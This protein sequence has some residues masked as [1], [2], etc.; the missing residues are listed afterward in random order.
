MASPGSPFDEIV[1]ETGLIRIA[2]FRCHPED[3]SFHDTGP[4]SNYCFVFP[5]TSVEIQHEHEPAFVANPNVVTFYNSGQR[6]QR[7]PISPEGDCCDWFGIAPDLV[8]DVIA[9]VDARAGDRMEQPFG[10]SHGKADAPTYLFQ[11]S[12]FT[13]VTTARRVDELFVEEAVITLLNQVIGSI[14]PVRRPARPAA[15]TP[16]HRA[17]IRHVET[18]L[19]KD[20]QKQAKLS[21]IAREVGSSPYHLCR[22]FR[23]VT[24][25]TLQRYRLRLRLRAAL[26]EVLDSNRSLTDIALEFGFSS[27]SHFTQS[28][29]REFGVTPSSLRPRAC[30]QFSDSAESH[31]ALVVREYAHEIP[32]QNLS[33]NNHPD[34]LYRMRSSA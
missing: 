6:Y 1:F 32:G 14:Y 27:H 29:G 31:V 34:C 2:A 5:R 3:P 10:I 26:A 15:I 21:G 25:T 9:A 30:E 11:R 23:R 28:F 7:N 17:V 19:S 33:H 24:G 22:L 18:L 8:R 13:H 20:L 4:A 12:L 16:H